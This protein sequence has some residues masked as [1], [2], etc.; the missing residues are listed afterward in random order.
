MSPASVVTMAVEGRGRVAA[1]G[2]HRD[3][4]R[5]HRGWGSA[6]ARATRQVSCPF[7]LRLA[8]LQMASSVYRLRPTA[9]ACPHVCRYL[10]APL[11]VPPAAKTR[12]FS[13]NSRPG[14]AATG[15]TSEATQTDVK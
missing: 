8:S 11:P 1:D 6:P 15:A 14:A 9:H 2:V 5:P 7:E 3:Y 4:F 10:E 13:G 12:R